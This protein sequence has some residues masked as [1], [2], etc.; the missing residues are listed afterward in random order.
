PI[1]LHADPLSSH[2]LLVSWR[3]SGP[4]EYFQVTVSHYDKNVTS[5]QP[6]YVYPTRVQATILVDGLVMESSVRS[7]IVDKLPPSRNCTVKLEACS[8][9]GCGD[10]LTTWAVTRPI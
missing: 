6:E 2:E 3:V 9:G 8:L 7:V 4:A 1:G 5:I 10:A